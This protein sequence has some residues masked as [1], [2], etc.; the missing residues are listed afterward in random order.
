VEE[1][2][3]EGVR[4]KNRG[5]TIRERKERRGGWNM[6]GSSVERGKGGRIEERIKAKLREE[7]GE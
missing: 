2:D 1:G 5:Y 7:G 4:R 3:D 6:R